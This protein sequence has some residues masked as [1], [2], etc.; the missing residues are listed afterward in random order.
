[1]RTRREDALWELHMKQ[2]ASNCLQLTDPMIFLTIYA[3]LE[4]LEPF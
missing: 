3:I 1:M 2:E 4:H